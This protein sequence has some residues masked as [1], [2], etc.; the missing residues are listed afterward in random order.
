[1][2]LWDFLKEKSIGIFINIGALIFVS[3]LLYLLNL[4]FYTIFFVS[5][6]YFTA[7]SSAL[8][9]EFTSKYSFYRNLEKSMKNLDKKYLLQE[10]IEPP[11]FLEGR[12]LHECLKESNK[13]MNDE[14]AKYKISTQEYREYIETWVHEI[15]TPIASSR[16]ILENNKSTVSSS[17]NEE[18]VKIEGFVEQVLYYSRSN[19]VE[20]DY[21]IKKSSLRD[22]VNAVIRKNSKTLIEEK[23]SIETENLDVFVFTDVKWIDFILGQLLSNSIKYMKIAEKEGI[24]PSER[25]KIRIRA[26][27][28]DNS[29]SLL[30]EDNGIG[31]P[32][33]DLNKVF[34]KGFTGENG[35]RSA[36][37]TGLGLYL[38]RKL[39]DKLG[40][41]IQLQS[42]ENR[43]TM[44]EIVF[45][46]S[47]MYA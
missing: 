45:P 30:L 11:A 40:L 5:A 2:S 9:I 27:E 35:R 34:D 19:T 4:N 24:I 20:K 7:F 46:K 36:K 6:V 23:I 37:S 8:I 32:E 16:L 28:K 3:M 47:N 10:V 22:I 33:K 18:L 39:C 21:I 41:N 43:G 44:V 38:C 29:I 1:M 26:L 31:I 25:R 12:I 17:L 13:S 42:K 14:I 15:K